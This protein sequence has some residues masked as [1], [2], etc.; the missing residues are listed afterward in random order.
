MLIVNGEPV[1]NAEGKSL[2]EYL[3]IAGYILER[4]AVERNGEIVPKN[5]YTETML[6]Q[7]DTIEVVQFVGGG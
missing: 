2:Y 7:G 6:M 4:I 1:S 5:R 3:K